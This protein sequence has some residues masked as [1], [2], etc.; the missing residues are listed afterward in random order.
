M[1]LFSCHTVKAELDRVFGHGELQSCKMPYA[2]SKEHAV[3]VHVVRKL[4]AL[5]TY[6]TRLARNCLIREM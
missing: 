1:P 4:L 3:S 2:L 5:G 6:K